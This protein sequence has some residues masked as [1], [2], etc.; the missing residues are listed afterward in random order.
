MSSLIHY[1]KNKFLLPLVATATLA[2]HYNALAQDNSNNK[3]SN[4]EIETSFFTHISGNTTLADGFELEI[5]KNEKGQIMD[6]VVASN[7][8]SSG[9]FSDGVEF[10]AGEDYSLENL[11]EDY[12]FDVFN[13]GLEHKITNRFQMGLNGDLEFYA[14]LATRNSQK[15]TVV[16][17]EAGKFF[18]RAYSVNG[19]LALKLSLLDNLDHATYQHW[20]TS[21]ALSEYLPAEYT[22]FGSLVKNAKAVLIY[23][24]FSKKEIGQS[25]AFLLQNNGLK[26]GLR[27]ND[28]TFMIG[29]YYHKWDLGLEMDGDL[30]NLQLKLPYKETYFSLLRE[31]DFFEIVGILGFEDEFFRTGMEAGFRLEHFD[32]VQASY[33]MNEKFIADF[34]NLGLDILNLDDQYF[35]QIEDYTYNELED[36]YALKPL[37]IYSIEGFIPLKNIQFLPY[38]GLGLESYHAGLSFNL[39]KIVGNFNYDS[40]Q[41]I[42]ADLALILGAD[43][44]LFMKMLQDERFARYTYSPIAKNAINEVKLREYYGKL[45]DL[46][47]SISAITRLHYASH[48]GDVT[49]LFASS[50]FFFEIMAGM[51]FDEDRSED[52]G[53]IAI[54]GPNVLLRTGYSVGR[55]PEFRSDFKQYSLDLG[56]TLSKDLMIIGS[57]KACKIENQTGAFIGLGIQGQW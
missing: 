50:K 3:Q 11:F 16:S 45:T 26:T 37:G 20:L 1:L 38:G 4:W 56:F 12:E 49:L 10:T 44:E 57:G 27:I 53:S 13:D 18:R 36:Q 51:V 33:Q 5:V 24:D 48:K 14:K 29:N 43:P 23:D 54:G 7:F 2:F 34:E 8:M 41:H 19:E 40:V 46:D 39:D 32:M 22:Q 47:S 17:L 21:L 9:L 52:Y 42:D 15:N 35:I 28:G 30:I 25:F 6:L 55:N 31:G